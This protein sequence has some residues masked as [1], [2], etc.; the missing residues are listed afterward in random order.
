MKKFLL[1]FLFVLSTFLLS[2]CGNEDENLKEA[3]RGLKEAEKNDLLER[4]TYL[5]YVDYFDKDVVVNKLTNQEVL[6]I[7]FDIYYR[8]NE[9]ADVIKFSKLEKIANDYLGFTLEAEDLLCNTHFNVLGGSEYLMLYDSEDGTYKYNDSHA[10]HG[11]GGLA[12]NVYNRFV[13]GSVEGNI[14]TI[15]VYKAFS[16][17]LGDVQE[18]TTEFYANYSDA[19]RQTNSLFQVTYN[20]NANKLNKDPNEL[21]ADVDEEKLEKYTYTF[22]LRDGN[23]IFTNYKKEA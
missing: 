4:I 3:V 16:E 8:L 20:F 9:N 10:G 17:I 12:S 7:S 2:G 21:L 19:V 15:T 23:Y 14:Y 1:C 18:D 6:Q 5:T 13:K 22:K 11:A